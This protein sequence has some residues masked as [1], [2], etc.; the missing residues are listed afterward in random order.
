MLFEPSQQN[1]IVLPSYFDPRANGESSVPTARGGLR[2]E[3]KRFDRQANDQEL[4]YVH[5]SPF[6]QACMKYIFASSFSEDLE[7][8]DFAAIVVLGVSML[9]NLA[10]V[11]SNVV[12]AA[13]GGQSTL[14]TIVFSVECFVVYAN[15]SLLIAVAIDTIRNEKYGCD[16]AADALF[17]CNNVTS[18]SVLRLLS[19]AS[20]SAASRVILQQ[21]HNARDWQDRLAVAYVILKLLAAFAIAIAAVVLKLPQVFF[22]ALP[23]SQWTASQWLQLIGLVLNLSKIDRS[24]ETETKILLGAVHQH[25]MPPGGPKDRD[26]RE[27]GLYSKLLQTFHIEEELTFEVFEVIFDFHFGV[28]FVDN[29]EGK[30]MKFW[31]F[32]AFLIQLDNDKLRKYLQMTQ[33]MAPHFESGRK[34]FQAAVLEQDALAMD[35]A[36]WRTDPT[37]DCVIDLEE[38][39]PELFRTVYTC[40]DPSE[41]IENAAQHL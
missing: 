3:M 33:S 30:K 27:L 36:L 20:P 15:F 9:I 6:D 12:T 19:Y 23:V 10:S 8:E 21:L 17:L 34:A 39:H 26:D 16:T 18:F 41:A 11:V 29:V 5:V 28:N 22:T 7:F 13:S 25:Y 35:L 1:G 40:V 14:S 24:Y 32:L 2:A 4:R 37:Q 31:N 38:A